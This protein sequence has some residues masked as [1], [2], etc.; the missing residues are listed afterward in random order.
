[1]KIPYGLSDFRQIREEGYFYAD[2][3]PFLPV[4]ETGYRTSCSFAR[5]ASASP[6]S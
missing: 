2:K 3:T 6:R 5:G 4:L 1:M